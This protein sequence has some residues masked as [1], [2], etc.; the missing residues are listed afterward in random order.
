MEDEAEKVKGEFNG[1]CNRSACLSPNDV[2][3]YNHST[4]LY[5]CKSCAMHL[6][7]VNHK[8]ALDC[9]GHQLCTK[10]AHLNE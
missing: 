3:W 10:G 9:F 2:T 8:D 1:L 4:R 5:Y 7:Y 6:N